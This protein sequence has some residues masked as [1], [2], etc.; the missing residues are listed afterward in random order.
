MPLRSACAYV[1]PFWLPGGHAQ[2]IGSRVVCFV[3]RIAYHRERL[4]LPDGDF[5]FVDWQFASKNPAAPSDKVAVISHGLEG[6]STRSYVRALAFALLDRGWDVAARNLRSCGGEM[7]RLPTFYH[8]GET[9]D[10]HSLVGH[11]L[12]KK[13]SSVALA[14]FSIGGN[15]TLKYLGERAAKVPPA[16]TA[17]AAVSVPCDLTG[18]SVALSK[19]A[20]RVYMEYFL[21][22]LRAKVREKKARYPDLFDLRGLEAMKTF[23]EFDDRFTAP[24][25]GFASAEDYW[26][27]ASSAPC[28]G[29]ITV[30]TLLINA[31]NDPFLNEECFPV[32]TAKASETLTLVMPQDGGHVGFPGP[33]GKTVGWLEREIVDFLDAN[34]AQQ[35]GSRIN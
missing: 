9:A 7:N 1:P 21:R 8:S 12:S 14:G 5:M 31:R 34:P 33:T 32:H 4:E 3:P 28:L 22:T 25:N 23:K 20:N 27:K 2:T 24:L 16:V 10:L 35:R 30:P 17:A 6:D 26:E 18:C 13:Y 15:Q 11:C 19:P 29:D